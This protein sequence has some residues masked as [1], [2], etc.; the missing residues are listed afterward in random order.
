M[1]LDLHN[2]GPTRNQTCHTSQ[3]FTGVLEVAWNLTKSNVANK[4]QQV[5][6]LRW[7][8]EN[9]T[10]NI[11]MFT[12]KYRHTH[13]IARMVFIFVQFSVVWT[14][15]VEQEFSAAQLPRNLTAHRSILFTQVR[16]TTRCKFKNILRDE[17]LKFNSAIGEGERLKIATRCNKQMCV[18][19]VFLML[20]CYTYKGV[21][22]YIM[23]RKETM[24]TSL[25]KNY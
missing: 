24:M 22:A 5:T 19:N 4:L 13:Y 25:Q 15:V 23:T 1:C 16:H 9:I 8:A 14:V 10:K 18:L 11:W 17:S 21:H 2:N 7:L 6:P 3:H 20:Q 12:F